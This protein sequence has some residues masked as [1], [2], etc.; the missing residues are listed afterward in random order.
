MLLPDGGVFAVACVG[1]CLV[2]AVVVVIARRG[3]VDL[4]IAAMLTSLVL[5]VLAGVA[6]IGEVTSA[7]LFCLLI[8]TLA[9]TLL[10]PRH[11][12]PVYV[13]TMATMVS[14][15]QLVDGRTRGLS[16][17]ELVGVVSL[18]SAFTAVT[19]AI[20]SI[21]LHDALAA[22]RGAQHDAQRL[23]SDLRVA[24]AQLERRVAERTRQL[25]ELAVRD[26][27]TR[28]HNR[29]H[30]ESELSAAVSWAAAT[31]E[32]L[33]LAAIDVDDFK[34]VNESFMHSGGDTVLRG[35][36]ALLRDAAR[37][38]DIVTR[39]GGEE[40][41]LVLPGATPEQAWERCEDLRLRIAAQAWPE[42][43][44]ELSVTVS[45]GLTGLRSGSDGEDLWRGADILLFDAKH[46]G[47]NRLICDSTLS[48]SERSG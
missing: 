38:G 37:P 19:A 32:P 48:S 10:R 22:E 20:N 6:V 15:P 2:Y 12:L 26:T 25:E 34:S 35:V 31:G 28:L 4:A 30:L 16:Y 33:A 14:L 44:D 45:I 3:Q 9:G 27:L 43:S 46:A 7:P 17:V 21:G 36:A 18:I 5:A 41:V 8:V 40:F 24:N 11:V 42:L 47:K 1:I 23:A 29:R 39:V 13:A